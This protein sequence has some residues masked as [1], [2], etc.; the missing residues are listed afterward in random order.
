MLST[1]VFKNKGPTGAFL[2]PVLGC[3]GQ[4]V[5]LA[6]RRAF[7]ILKEML[8]ASEKPKSPILTENNIASDCHLVKNK[9]PIL[10]KLAKLTCFSRSAFGTGWC[11][12]PRHPVSSPEL[13]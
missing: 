9:L 10:C 8:P 6:T 7:I 1:H 12:P 13:E 2:F 11:S 5:Y 4:K 3:Y